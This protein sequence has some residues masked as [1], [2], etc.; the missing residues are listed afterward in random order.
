[1]V[2]KFQPINQI[3]LLLLV[4]LRQTAKSS[5]IYQT[6]LDLCLVSFIV[7]IVPIF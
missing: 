5:I 1:M 7:P 6:F 4:V 3:L 2:P